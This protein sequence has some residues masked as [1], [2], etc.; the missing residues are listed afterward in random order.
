MILALGLANTFPVV[1][2][3]LEMIYKRK[4][5]TKLVFSL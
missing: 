2:L 4:S 5:S 3:Y 1:Y